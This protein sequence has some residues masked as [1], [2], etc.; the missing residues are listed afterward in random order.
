M[1]IEHW[2]LNQYYYINIFIYLGRY[3]GDKVKCN[4]VKHGKTNIIFLTNAHGHLSPAPLNVLFHIFCDT[5]KP[6]LIFPPSSNV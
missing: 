2:T 3:V 5:A 1:Y 4:S 6:S